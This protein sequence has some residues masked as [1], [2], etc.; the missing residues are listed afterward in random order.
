MTIRKNA[1]LRQLTRLAILS[2]TAICSTSSWADNLNVLWIGGSQYNG[3]VAALSTPGSGDPSTTTWTVTTYSSGAVN[4]A[5]Y[6]VVLVGTGYD[7]TLAGITGASTA[8]TSSSRVFLTGQDADYHVTYG[9]GSLRGFDGPRG[10]IRDAVAWA[11]GGTGTGFVLLDPS[12]PGSLGLT[13]LGTVAAGSQTVAI[14]SQY[15]AFPINTGLTTAGLSNWNQSSHESWTGIDTSLWTGINTTQVATNFVTIVSAST[16]GAGAAG[17]STPPVSSSADIVTANDDLA[18]VGSSINPRFNGGTLVT[19]ASGTTSQNF[20]VTASGGVIDAG[21][22][23]LT[24]L[25]SLSDDAAGSPGRLVL[26]VLGHGGIIILRPATSNTLTGGLQVNAGTTLQISSGAAL[27]TGTLQ[28]V[29]TATTPAILNVDTTTTI[30]N[31]VQ[32]SGD[33]VFNIASGTTTT[34]S[35]VISDGS[36]PGDV[37]VNNDGTST[38]TLLLTANNTYTGGT[39][40][41]AGTL[42]L[43]G[44]GTLGDMGGTT[45]V[46]GGTL[47]LGTTTQTQANLNQSGGLVTNGTMGVGT[48]QLTGGTLDTSATVNAATSFDMQAGTVNGVL[49]GAGAL[50]KS[51]TG[52]VTLAGANTYTGGTTVND[53]TLALSGA[54]SIASSSGVAVMSGATLDISAATAPETITNLTGDGSVTLG[55]TALTL[56]NASGTFAGTMSGTAG[57]TV[58]GG[59]ATLT[60]ANTYTGDTTIAS[61]ATLALGANTA[62]GTIAGNV[63]DNGTLIVNHTDDL[64]FGG[65]ISGTGSLVKQN[66]DV[67]TLTGTSALSTATTLRGRKLAHEGRLGTST[68]TVGNTATLGGTGTLAGNLVVASGGTLSSGNSPG[69]LTVTGNVTLNGGANF[70][71]ELDG[72]IY[73]A[74]G[75][76]GSYDRLVLSGA[77]STFNAGGTISP[78]LRGISGGAT[79]S[80][81]PAYGDKFTVVTASAIGSGAF[82]G[83]VQPTA[84]MPANSRF[85]VLYNAQNVQLVLTPGSFHALGL[86]DGWQLNGLNA[87]AGLDAVRGQA[88]ARSAN[89]QSLFNGLYGMNRNQLGLAFQQVSGEIHADALQANGANID[90]M[91]SAIDSVDAGLGNGNAGKPNLWTQILGRTSVAGQDRTAGRYTDTSSGFMTGLNFVHGEDTFGLAGGYLDGHVHN[92]I[93]SQ[94]NSKYGSMFLHGS[95][96]LT[97]ALALSGSIGLAF[98]NTTTSRDLTLSTGTTTATSRSNFSAVN[99]EMKLRYGFQLAGKLKSHL[100]AGLIYNKLTYHAV[101]EVN[102]ADQGLALSLPGSDWKTF[103]STV[104]GDIAFSLGNKAEFVVSGAWNHEINNAPTASRLVTMGPASW[105]VSTVTASGE[106]LSIGANLAVHLSERLTASFGYQGTFDTQ[107]YSAHRGNFALG[108]KF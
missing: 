76:S 54:G 99:G 3:S 59:T 98:G 70:I 79:N 27:G 11:G 19:T 65:T 105:S 32:V 58:A 81:T 95:K 22:H 23:V 103:Q 63:V 34:I 101:K 40:V 29:G 35:G 52:T 108:L 86:A 107:R 50:T 83:V 93:G 47:D 15:A 30:S 84:G 67:L 45:T 100:F 41:N 61:G 21:G 4:F 18:N 44:A 46:A 13:G 17:I 31:A 1:A 68:A 88:G 80:F 64:T 5:D 16:A 96:Q 71:T 60:G 66:A 38:G 73:S 28:L 94:A 2:T 20:T 42:A 104:G 33:P 89:L 6:N 62:S 39:I 97:P 48:Y 78:V 74:A 14:P 26:G 57:L 12:S 10:F 106:N 53:G 49:G 102:A 55:G 75:G 9:P 24:F 92:G 91:R 72:R 82:S 87:A 8:V 90:L 43:S 56:S 51:T 25:G 7:S 69:T 36:A 37:V 77:T 85:D